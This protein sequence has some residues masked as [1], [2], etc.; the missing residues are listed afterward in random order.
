[1]KLHTL[2]VI[3][4]NNNYS[5]LMFI[6]LLIIIVLASARADMAAAPYPLAS[7]SELNTNVQNNIDP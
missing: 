6:W 1:M 2:L 7:A 3:Y 4:D 5:K